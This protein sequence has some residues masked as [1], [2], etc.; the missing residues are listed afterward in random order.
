MNIHVEIFPLLVRGLTQGQSE[1]LVL[2]ESLGN[3]ATLR[4]L[5]DQL[6]AKRPALG[7]VVLD[8]GTRCPRSEIT[9]S[10]NEQ[11]LPLLGALD[12]DLHDGDRVFLLM[13]MPGG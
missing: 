12:T 4:Q 2:E 1:R 7:E 10:V 9:V 3:C 8:P 13:A 5:V 6:V 11:L